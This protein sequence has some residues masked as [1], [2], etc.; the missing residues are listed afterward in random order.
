MKL[1]SGRPTPHNYEQF[2]TLDEY[3][4]WFPNNIAKKFESVDHLISYIV[5]HHLITLS[6]LIASELN[7]PSKHDLLV[8]KYVNKLVGYPNLKD[9]ILKY[10]KNRKVI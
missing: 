5:N 7:K 1:K 4:E 2:K 3:V 10:Y 8:I 6:C 9:V